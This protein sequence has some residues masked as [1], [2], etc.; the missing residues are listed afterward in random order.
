MFRA[1]AGRVV[2]GLLL[3]ALSGCGSSSDEQPHVLLLTAEGTAEI[4]SLKFTLDGRVVRDGAA[5]LPWSESLSLPADG[6]EHTWALQ[7]EHGDGDLELAATVDGQLL[8]QGSGS[9]SGGT[10]G[11]VS[12]DGAIAG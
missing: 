2:V 8:T 1:R 10:T 9:G 3:M 6:Q 5:T 12:I 7:A 11:H 4:K